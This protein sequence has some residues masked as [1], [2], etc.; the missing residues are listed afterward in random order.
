MPPICSH[1][2]LRLDVSSHAAEAGFARPPLAKR[3][4]AATPSGRVVRAADKS[5]SETLFPGPLVLPDDSLTIDP[6]EPPQSLRSW[7]VEKHRNPIT[8][9]RKTIYVS[10]PPQVAS[11]LCLTL[12]KWIVPSVLP[13]PLKGGCDAPKGKQIVEYLAAFYHP[14]PVKLL[15]DKVSF[16]PWTEGK[17]KQPSKSSQPEYVG[18]QVGTGVTRITT[19]PCPDDVYPRQLNLTDIL[20]AAIESLPSDAYALVMLTDH[21]LYEDDEDVFCCGR[22]YGGSRVAVAS[23]ARYHPLLDDG[24]EI[25]REHMWPFSHCEA[26]VQG[27]YQDAAAAE[28]AGSASKKRKLAPPDAAATTGAGRQPMAEVIQAGLL[29]PP[30]TASLTGL[31]LARMARTVSHEVG[32]CFC[33]AHC[34]YYACVMQSSA[35]IHEDLRQPPY[36]CLVCLAKLTRGVSDIERGVNGVQL[37]IGRYTALARFCEKWKRVAMFAAYRCWL[38]TRIGALKATLPVAE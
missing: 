32:H 20:D 34:P 7:I 10:P 3:K 14:L 9:R 29:A 18:L 36:L 24:E 21:D 27:A 25:D 4:A 22:A 2:H 23:S 8:Q 37:M 30:P 6:T 28:T 35:G 16:V 33:L 5:H 26:Y 13:G 17:S 19:R 1:D 15:P 38:E 31:W 11:E 12:H